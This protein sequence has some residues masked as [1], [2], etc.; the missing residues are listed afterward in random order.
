MPG[1]ENSDE[2]VAVMFLILLASRARETWVLSTLEIQNVN[3]Q[4]LNEVTDRRHRRT[5]CGG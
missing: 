1:K 2:A 3:Q 5:T 4:P